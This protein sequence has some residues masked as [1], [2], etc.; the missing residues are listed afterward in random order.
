MFEML[1][2]LAVFMLLLFT[3]TLVLI[4][5]K[6][7]VRYIKDAFAEEDI[8][9]WMLYGTLVGFFVLIVPILINAYIDVTI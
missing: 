2:G 6:Q 9:N 5:W 1:A 3:L 8:P 4:F 7:I